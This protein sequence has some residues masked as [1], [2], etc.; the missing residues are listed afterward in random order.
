MQHMRKTSTEG[1]K[2]G[3][4]DGHKGRYGFD[5]EY[6]SKFL[7][8]GIPHVLLHEGRDVDDVMLQEI[9]DKTGYQAALPLHPRKIR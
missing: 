9:Y 3:Y 2:A 6:Q 5:A 8:Q 4:R 1:R 7:L